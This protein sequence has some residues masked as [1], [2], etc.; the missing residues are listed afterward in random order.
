MTAV[1]TDTAW[2]TALDNTITGLATATKALGQA[3]DATEQLQ[4]VVIKQAHAIYDL[5]QY[6]DELESENRVLVEHL[7]R[8]EFGSEDKV[9]RWVDAVLDRR[10]EGAGSDE[11][12]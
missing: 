8:T 6:R 4:V 10:G 1:D 3:I 7:A 12:R 5:M 11:L 2:E 9:R